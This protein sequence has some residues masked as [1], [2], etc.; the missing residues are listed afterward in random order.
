LGLLPAS[1]CACFAG[2]IKSERS[3]ELPTFVPYQ[4]LV[5]VIQTFQ[6]QWIDHTM[7]CLQKT[8]TELGKELQQVVSHYFERF[9]GGDEMANS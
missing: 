7:A 3:T 8:A 6:G 5:K 1:A 2:I 9:P 4:A